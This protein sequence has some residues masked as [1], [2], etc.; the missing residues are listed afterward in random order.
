MERS[1]LDVGTVVGLG[2]S[3]V[4][5][6]PTV[7]LGTYGFCVVESRVIPGK[8]GNV[9]SVVLTISGLRVVVVVVVVEVVVLAVVDGVVDGVV[10]RVVEEATVGLDGLRVGAAVVTGFLVE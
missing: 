9:I 2:L 10:K 8:G 7:T 6:V 1:V 3:V 4:R 5:L